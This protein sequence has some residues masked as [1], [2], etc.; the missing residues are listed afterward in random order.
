MKSAIKYICIAFALLQGCSQESGSS[1]GSGT[2]DLRAPSQVM[3]KQSAEKNAAPDRVA[4]TGT[5]EKEVAYQKKV[6][7]W[8][9]VTG[10]KVE[11]WKCRYIEP[12]VLDREYLID[13]GSIKPAIHCVQPNVQIKVVNHEIEN[14]TLR[15]SDPTIIPSKLFTG[16]YITF[17]G[18]VSSAFVSGWS[19]KI[20][21]GFALE[22][23][24]SSAK[25]SEKI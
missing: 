6:E 11:E 10:M 5:R 8:K 9:N 18:T 1:T 21:L 7:F 16:D 14:Y 15:F 3:F 19:S 20:D 12:R 2:T 25:F 17:S 4:K 24:V 22:I 13:D 23:D